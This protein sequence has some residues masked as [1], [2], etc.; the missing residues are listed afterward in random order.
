[1]T[2]TSVA[3]IS[4]LALLATC[5]TAP[6]APA[7]RTLVYG[8]PDGPDV[9]VRMGA[10]EIGL[11]LPDRQAVLSQ[12][13][14]ASG[15]KYQEGDLVFWSKG[16]EALLEVAGARIPGCR[17]DPARAPW[18]DARLR[19]AAFRAVGN[20]PGWHLEIRPDAGIAF[21]GDYGET[22][23]R[24]P[25]PAPEIDPQAGERLYRAATEAHELR[26]TIREERC[27]DDMSGEA[28]PH[29]VVVVLDGREHRGCGRELGPVFAGDWQLARFGSGDAAGAAVVGGSEPTLL[30]DAWGLAAG[31]TGCNR[32]SGAYAYGVR[33]DLSF[34]PLATTRRACPGPL[35]EQESRFL[36]ALA[37]AKSYRLPGAELQL[38]DAAG[39]LLLVLAARESETG[40]KD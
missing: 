10:G 15:A 22:E 3:G 1:M 8:C 12:V 9:V 7:G 38:L 29:R 14:S 16:D 35:M 2:G 24:T 19:R 23:V 13:P 4:L 37:R 5:A 17:L 6:S 30:L 27:Q 31:S 25:A 26:V 40:Q 36:D 20:E 33:P 34:G 11:F 32:F 28:F 39:E 18:E 21:V